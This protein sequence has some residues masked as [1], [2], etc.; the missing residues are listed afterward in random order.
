MEFL[1]IRSFKFSGF[2]GGDPRDDGEE[3]R[4]GHGV[5][6]TRIRSGQR[7][8]CRDWRSLPASLLMPSPGDVPQPLSRL[9]LRCSHL[10]V[11]MGGS[12]VE[13]EKLVS[14]LLSLLAGNLN[15]FKTSQ[16][17]FKH[18]LNFVKPN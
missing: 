3:E 7:L 2:L 6:D 18:H 10:P 4:G 13:D 17:R 8:V 1:L 16:T 9:L 15:L 5:G 11:F 14:R 12:G